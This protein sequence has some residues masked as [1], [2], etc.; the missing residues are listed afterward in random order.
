MST[1]LI[2]A[3]LFYRCLFLCNLFFFCGFFC[4]FFLLITLEALPERADALAQ[5]LAQPAQP[6]HAEDEEYNDQYEYQ[7]WPTNFERH[8]FPL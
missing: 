5:I 1:C 7:L 4:V 6:A 2:V 8:F 3:T